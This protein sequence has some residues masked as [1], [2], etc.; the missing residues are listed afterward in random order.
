ME[1]KMEEK[2]ELD[3]KQLKRV[4]DGVIAEN[5]KV[6]YNKK[7]QEEFSKQLVELKKK[8]DEVSDSIGSIGTISAELSPTV[9]ISV[10]KRIGF[11]FKRAAEDVFNLISAGDN[12]TVE[13]INKMFPA[14]NYSQV[15]GIVK[16]IRAM[17]GVR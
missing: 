3:V 7:R 15:M 14:L 11:N 9:K 1:G 17:P 13:K 6:Q 16:H 10:G 4:L 8:L 12:I 2:Q 5:E